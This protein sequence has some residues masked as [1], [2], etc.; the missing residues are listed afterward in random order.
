VDGEDDQVF[1]LTVAEIG[2]G[3]VLEVEHLVFDDLDVSEEVEDGGTVFVAEAVE[4]RVAVFAT[5]EA[6]KAV[7]VQDA[8]RSGL[9]LAIPSPSPSPSSSPPDS[10]RHSCGSASSGAA[11]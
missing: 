6:G 10:L 8:L 5:E 7:F 9:L 4:L 3:E 11:H 2:G 1:F